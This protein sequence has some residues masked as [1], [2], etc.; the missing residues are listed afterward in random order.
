[1]D[2]TAVRRVR[3]H[4]VRG[5]KAVA[6]LAAV[7]AGGLSLPGQ[8]AATEGPIP[9]VARWKLATATGTPQ[10]SPGEGS[11]GAG[12]RLGGGA[13]IDGTEHLIPAPG[14]MRL[15]GVDGY[16]EATGLPL[17]T[18]RSFTLAGWANPVGNPTK[19]MTVF[20]FAGADDSAVT[21]RWHY[22]R[23]DPVAG[24]IGEWQAE[25]R[26]ADGTGSVTTRVN[27]SDWYSVMEHWTHLAVSYD[28]DASRF[29]LYVDGNLERQVCE[30]GDPDCREYVSTSDTAAPAYDA[31]G[32]LQI[33]RAR[34]GG[35]WT[36]YF[37]GEL[38]DIWVF[39]GAL[40][41]WRIAQL[42]DY[43]VELDTST[44]S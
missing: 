16:A 2:A 20:S 7:A 8:A 33:G 18:D 23:T 11:S 42:A 38:D 43:N 27:H 21:V 31:T 28:A 10:V 1:M 14:I 41:D 12:L 26:D 4:R 40:S 17:H 6:V 19:D 3:A 15:D 30:P 39:Q 24:P 9:A 44:V 22:L 37:E 5:W 36:E 34:S 35:A 29:T 13:E 32:G 25:L